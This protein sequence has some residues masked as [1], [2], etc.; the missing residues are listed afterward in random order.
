MKDA[1]AEAAAEC[2]TLLAL[3]SCCARDVP[4]P[5][6]L[7]AGVNDSRSRIEL[8]FLFQVFELTAEEEHDIGDAIGVATNDNNTEVNYCGGNFHGYGPCEPSQTAL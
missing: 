1:R 8:A 4:T 6:A 3:H 5:R 2:T 7:N